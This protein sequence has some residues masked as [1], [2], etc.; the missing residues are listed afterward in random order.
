MWKCGVSVFRD[1]ER[2]MKKWQKQF[3]RQQ[4]QNKKVSFTDSTVLFH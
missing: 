1:R 2:Q 4:E 3:G